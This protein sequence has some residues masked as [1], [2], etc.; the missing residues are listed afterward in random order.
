MSDKEKN[1]NE[2]FEDDEKL[3]LIDEDLD[4]LDEEVDEDPKHEDTEFD[5]LFKSRVNKHKLEGTH[6]LKR[7]TIF[8]GKLDEE[9]DELEDY[10]L[11]SSIS[12]YDTDNYDIEKGSTYEVETRHYQDYYYKK[13]LTKDIYDILDNKTEIDFV[14]NRRKPNKQTFNNYYKMC[15]ED[16]GMKYSKSEIFVELSYYFTDN[17]FNMFKLLNKKHATGIIVELKDKGYLKDI[18]NI[19]FV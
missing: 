9:S 8:M 19:N 4:E 16:L 14:E 10:E 5:I 13:S 6:S 3:D 1:L 17:I 7:D 15:V 11:S 18:G 2:D 12:D